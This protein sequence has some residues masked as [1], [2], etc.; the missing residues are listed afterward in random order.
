LARTDG[1]DQR[2]EALVRERL[3]E[4]NR[5]GRDQC[6]AVETIAAYC[7]RSLARSERDAVEGHLAGCAACRAELTAIGRAARELEEAPAAQPW[8]SRWW[9]S[10][11]V[12]LAVAGTIGLIVAIGLGREYYNQEAP[13]PAQL[14]MRM[15]GPASNAL[16]DQAV[17]PAAKSIAPNVELEA[18]AP[19]AAR[20][21]YEPLRADER[22]EFRAVPPAAPS[23]SADAAGGRAAH[24]ASLAKSAKSERAAAN[25]PLDTTRAVV[26]APEEKLS[27]PPATA[28]PVGAPQGMLS[29]AKRGAPEGPQAQVMAGAAAANTGSA[30]GGA[31]SSTGP[32]FAKPW[33]HSTI[34]SADGSVRWEFGTGGIIERFLPG[35]M[36]STQ[37]PGVTAE[38]LAGS[39]PS[40]SVCWI[41]GRGGTVLRTTDG[42]HWEKTNSPTTADLIAVNAQGAEAAI[43]TDQDSRRWAT[44]DGARTWHAQ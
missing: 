14:A 2:F 9:S 41:V 27:P 38:L 12:G 22:R 11:P 36:K 33:R 24:Q 19:S 13:R 6:P 43:V 10:A 31:G 4:R 23:A 32:T 35:G 40:S 21:P 39:A 8:L 29:S 42:V 1:I 28:P 26:A 44:D 37:V 34:T 3:S 16:S 15:A 7:E 5:E 20:A 25:T 30:M 18:S 17:P